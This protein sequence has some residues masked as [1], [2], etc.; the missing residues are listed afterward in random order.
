MHLDLYIN[1]YV[2]TIGKYS[3]NATQ[4]SDIQTCV[5]NDLR[6]GFEGHGIVE[7]SWT[8]HDSHGM[9]YVFIL[10]HISYIWFPRNALK[11][12]DNLLEHKKP[13]GTL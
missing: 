10:Q 4:L 9:Y 8:T 6:P 11:Y 1:T 7:I 5:S 2:Y 3:K 13:I 12:I